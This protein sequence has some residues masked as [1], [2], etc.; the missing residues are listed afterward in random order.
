M[1]TVFQ[2]AGANGLCL[3]EKLAWRT[4]AAKISVPI[5]FYRDAEVASE[6]KG[7]EGRMLNEMKFRR[8]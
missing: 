7:R 6:E 3:S 8:S 1:R 4:G 2:I 5:I